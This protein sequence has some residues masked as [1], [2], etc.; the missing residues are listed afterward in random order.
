MAG[1]CVQDPYIGIEI[2]KNEPTEEEYNIM[3]SA[4]DKL[5]GESKKAFPVKLIN[6]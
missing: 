3:N 5:F 1:L 4:I 6:L 2:N